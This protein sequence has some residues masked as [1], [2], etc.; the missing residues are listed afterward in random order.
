MKLPLW[1][2]IFDPGKTFTQFQKLLCE[3]CETCETSPPVS[4]PPGNHAKHVKLVRHVKIVS[5]LL[6]REKRFTQNETLGGKRFTQ[7]EAYH[8][9][10]MFRTK[11]SHDVKLPPGCEAR[12]AGVSHVSHI[13][14]RVKLR[15][16]TRET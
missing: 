7:H 9:F 3:T 2:E 16:A 15:C 14:H 13:S 1:C 4:D 10:H 5:R 6:C 8:M 11:V 12:G